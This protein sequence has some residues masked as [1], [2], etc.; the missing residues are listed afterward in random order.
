[1]EFHDAGVCIKRLRNSC[2]C[3]RALW[4]TYR[5]AASSPSCLSHSVQRLATFCTTSFRYSVQ[6]SRFPLFISSIPPLRATTPLSQRVT[7]FPRRSSHKQYLLGTSYCSTKL[8]LEIFLNCNWID[9][10]WQQY[11]TLLHTNNTQNNTMKHNI[12]NR[13]YITIKIHTHITIRIHK[14]N[15]KNT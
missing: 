14:H 2:T 9:T 7:D 13:T 5:S 1:M 8:V 6:S 12:K 11:S 4:S 15:N 10:R 3:G